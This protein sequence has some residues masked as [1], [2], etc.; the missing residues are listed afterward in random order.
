MIYS[1]CRVDLSRY[2]GPDHYTIEPLESLTFVVLLL[3]QF[4]CSV[5]VCLLLRVVPHGVF[6]VLVESSLDLLRPLI[7]VAYSDV[8]VVKPLSEVTITSGGE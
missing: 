8:E 3:K 1:T 6:N 2:P 7:D 5:M 4:H